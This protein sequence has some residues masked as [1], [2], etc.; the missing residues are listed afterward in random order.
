[1]TFV[2]EQGRGPQRSPEQTERLRLELVEAL[3][4]DVGADWVYDDPA[5]LDTYA[6]QYVAEAATGSQYMPRPLAVVLPADTHEVSAVV[7]T[8]NRLGVQYKA[9]STGFGMWNASMTPDNLVQIDLRRLDRIVEIDSQNMIAV[10]EPYVTGNQLQTEAMKVGLNTHIAGC[11]AQCSSLASATSM[12]G[13]G[14]DGVSMGFSN[15][16]LLG[17]EW[18]MPDGEIVRVGSFDASGAD[19]LGDGPGFSVRGIVRGFAGALGG[20]G[21]FTRAAIKLYPWEGPSKLEMTGTSPSYDVRIPEHHTAAVIV[22]ND[23]DGMAELGYALGEAGITTYL[24]RNAPSLMA[25]VLGSDNHEGA[26]LYRIPMMHELYYSLMCVMTARSAEEAAWQR[27]VLRKIVADLGGGC[28]TSDLSLAAAWSF[29]GALRA[30]TRRV[31]VVGMARSIPGMLRMLARDVRRYGIRRVPTAMQGLLYQSL[32][33]SGMNMRGVFRFAGTFWTAMGSLVSW[34]NA[35]RGAKVGAQVKKKYIDRGLI[36]DDGGDNAWGGL[37]EGGA[38]AHLEELALYDPRDP[39][40]REGV[41]EYIVETNLACIEHHCGDSLNAVGPLNHALFSPV[42]MDYDRHTQRI[43]KEF[44]PANA[45][46]ASMYTDPDFAP[47]GNAASAFA[48]AN[49]DR[50]PIRI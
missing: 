11:G 38:Y 21:V 8:C 22:V 6:W 33:R 45:A 48:R 39:T 42:C 27:R 47:T 2:G 12:M 4:K 37:Y 31:G 49:A 35:I 5:V 29:A 17:F 7:R 40:C 30:I 9:M 43:K 36:V 19:F 3:V 13:Q 44:D 28:L 10:I 23:W 18:V 20:L 24:G 25:G 14:W 46:D 26:E 32:V 50:A 1:M 15:R 41:L 34:D 16:N